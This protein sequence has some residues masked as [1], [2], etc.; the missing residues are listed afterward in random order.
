M[1]GS[2]YGYAWPESDKIKPQKDI[3]GE[4]DSL[5]AARNRRMLALPRL[6]ALPRAERDSILVDILQ[7]FLKTCEPKHYRKNVRPVITQ[8]DF[9]E[10][11]L[12]YSIQPRKPYPKYLEPTDICYEVMLYYPR[13]RDEGFRYPYTAQAIIREKSRELC[14]VNLGGKD[15]TQQSW[16]SEWSTGQ[17]RWD[18]R[19]LLA[20]DRP[21]TEEAE[22]V[23]WESLKEYGSYWRMNDL[24][25]SVSIGT[26]EWAALEWLP[27][28]EMVPEYVEPT[29]T[30]YRVRFYDT[31]WRERKLDFPLMAEVYID[32]RLLEV[33]RKKIV[34]DNVRWEEWTYSQIRKKGS[35]RANATDNLHKRTDP[36]WRKQRPCSRRK[37]NTVGQRQRLCKEC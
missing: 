5:S 13:W 16:F 8:G 23:A 33:F 14:K 17:L 19:E 2:R 29:D 30:C 28:K 7:H 24:E 27:W 37:R 21:R 35:S 15:G 34:F 32:D 25:A 31:K 20:T 1:L 12:F 10:E 26:F 18:K 11:V 22:R 4:R 9:R 6:S 36:H 3:Y